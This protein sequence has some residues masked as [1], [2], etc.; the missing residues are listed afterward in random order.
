MRA[1]LS[2]F[3]LSSFAAIVN[4]TAK[5]IRKAGIDIAL[6]QTVVPSI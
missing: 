5:W 2:Q 6:M 3:W 4:V 1:A